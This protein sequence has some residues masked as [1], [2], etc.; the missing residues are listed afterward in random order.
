[1]KR[2]ER[3]EMRRGKRRDYDRQRRSGP[4]AE[5]IRAHDT[6]RKREE[7]RAEGV[8]PREQFL[9]ENNQAQICRDYG[10]GRTTYYRWKNA[11]ILEEKLAKRSTRG[12]GQS[13]IVSD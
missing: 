9:E 6:E 8:K 12:T 2:E 11:G 4:E 5:A 13:D 3:A 10:I 1:M 7:R